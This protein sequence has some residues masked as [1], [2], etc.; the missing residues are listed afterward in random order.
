MDGE[1]RQSSNFEFAFL[2]CNYYGYD[3]YS[4]TR[5]I[6]PAGVDTYLGVRLTIDGDLHY[7]WIGVNRTGAY[8]DVLSWGYETEAGVG[9]GAG[10]PAPGPLGM[11]ALGAAG[12]LS[13]KK[14]QA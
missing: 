10:V 14:R 12:A 2:A 4:G 13:R 6:I 11:L 1:F 9:V 5:G 7:G 3:C 8:L